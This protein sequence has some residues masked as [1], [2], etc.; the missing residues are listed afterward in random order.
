MNAL[1]S[2]PPAPLAPYPTPIQ[3]GWA[4]EAIE[5]L[6]RVCDDAVDPASLAAADRAWLARLVEGLGPDVLDDLEEAEWPCRTVRVMYHDMWNL[7]ERDPRVVAFLASRLG[8]G[9]WP[10]T[11]ADMWATI[12]DLGP[13]TGAS[14]EVAAWYQTAQAVRNVV[15]RTI[16]YARLDR[17]V[18]PRHLLGCGAPAPDDAQ[19]RPYYIVAF[20]APPP[21][22]TAAIALVRAAS[23]AAD[24]R[25]E[26]VEALKDSRSQFASPDEER[27]P[28]ARR[29]LVAFL[30][31][32]LRALRSREATP[33]EGSERAAGV[34]AGAARA[35][36][37]LQGPM[38]PSAAPFDP[39]ALLRYSSLVLAG[40]AAWG[41]WFDAC[42]LNA[43][44]DMTRGAIEAQRAADALRP[45]GPARA[46]LADYT[47]DTVASA[48]VAMPPGPEA[49]ALAESLDASVPPHL[50][51]D[52]AAR[53]W[54]RVCA[55][56][57]QPPGALEGASW[58][59]RVAP[60]L[61]ITP[62]AAQEAVPELLC[63]TLAPRVAH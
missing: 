53:T 39:A 8:Q 14:P 35:A 40:A 48:L 60:W 20:V 10:P 9:A 13:R 24:P 16:D 18:G 30:R 19:G 4:S 50:L 56:D 29:L 2:L 3:P 15:N 25:Y 62:T 61:G 45:R 21:A 55:Q 37:V 5:R 46:T 6:I 51:R 11:F 57:T 28:D 32:V 41:A 49:D 36:A 52:I 44:L 26:V 17:L 34:T 43:L 58:L 59:P 22:G 27:M 47:T 23:A 63:G 38:N 31:E 42:R 7:L 54:A 33:P 1:S 12:A